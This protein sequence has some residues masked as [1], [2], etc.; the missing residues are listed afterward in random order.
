MKPAF[1]T[2]PGALT[3]AGGA[4]GGIAGIAGCT[5]GAFFAWPGGSDA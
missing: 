3:A 4:G 2:C 5:L 1:L